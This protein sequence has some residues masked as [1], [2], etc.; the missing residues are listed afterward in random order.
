[1]FATYAPDRENTLG[2]RWNPSGVPAIYTSLVRETALAEAEF[3]IAMQPL[4]PKAKRTIYGIRVT[5]VSVFDLSTPTLLAAMGISARELADMDMQDC[6]RVGAA[7]EHSQHDGLLVPSAR[8][9]GQNLVIYPRR[10]TSE[11]RFEIISEEMI[12]ARGF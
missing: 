11:F 6:Q 7:V 3:Q 12:E 2:A 4:R 8:H 5:L 10:A 9:D 1:M